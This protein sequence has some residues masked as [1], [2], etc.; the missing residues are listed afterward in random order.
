[1]S[2]RCASGVCW[3]F[4]FPRRFQHVVQCVFV[5]IRTIGNIVIVTTLLQFMFACIGVQLFKV[6]KKSGGKN[7]KAVFF[8]ASK[9]MFLLSF[10]FFF[11]SGQVLLVHRQLQANSGWVQVR[12]FV[13]AATPS[14]RRK[15]KRAC[16]CVPAGVPTSCIRTEMSGNRKGP[17]DYGRTANLT[18]TMFC[19]AWWRCSLCPPSRGGQGL[20]PRYKC[21]LTS[22]FGLLGPRLAFFL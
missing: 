7:S 2:A 3:S 14:I 12:P 18:S 20:C 17:R 1:M 11:K 19:K 15:N 6:R 8:P 4:V 9:S 13:Y 22:I 10:F 16:V 5:A 21:T